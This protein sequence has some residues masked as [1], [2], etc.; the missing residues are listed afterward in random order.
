MQT[1]IQI[2]GIV[3][4]NEAVNA[5]S[6]AGQIQKAG[7][8]ILFVVDSDGGEVEEGFKI[9]Q[10]IESC[11]KKTTSIAKRVVSIANVI[12]L[13]AETRICEPSSSFMIHPPFFSGNI[14]ADEAT[15]VEL[16]K[17]IKSASARILE[18]YEKRTG[19]PKSTLEPLFTAD[20][21]FGQQDALNLN[22]S[23]FLKI[24]NQMV[25]KE[26]ANFLAKIINAFKNAEDM[27][28]IETED[29]D[30]PPAT[31]EAVT[32]EDTDTPPATNEAV[33]REEFDAL[34]MEMVAM[35]EQIQALMAASE[36]IA[37]NVVNEIVNQYK[38]A[39]KGVEKLPAVKNSFGTPQ[40]TE[41][42]GN[43]DL[44]KFA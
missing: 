30:T 44:S 10:M 39:A 40:P 37:Q 23:N 8:E 4:V 32:R 2:N 31:N 33:T 11:G 38:A 12:Y 14:F 18:Y 16:T 42:N 3:G 9:A 43:L 22:F 6:I 17:E 36:N 35:Q 7:E 24:N 15:L 26:E 28:E 20:R 19:T 5:L 27:P 25:K 41:N 1:I 13:A 34:K 21:W 29:T